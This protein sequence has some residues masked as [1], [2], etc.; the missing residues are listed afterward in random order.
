MTDLADIPACQIVR[1]SPETVAQWLLARNEQH[2][3][4]LLSACQSL[5]AASLRRER[6]V[7]NIRA[8]AA[9]TAER[10]SG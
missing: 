2:L 4:R 1:Y 3:T 6:A 10:I 9:P 5:R 7:E 8:A